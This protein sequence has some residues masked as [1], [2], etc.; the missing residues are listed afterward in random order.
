MKTILMM[1]ITA[2][3]KIAKEKNHLADWTSKEDKQLFVKLTKEAGAIIMGRTTYETIG[4]PLPGR[5]I[6]ALTST[7]EKYQ[8]I[9]GQVEYIKSETGREVLDALSAKGY[10]SAVL[11]GGAVT[12]E[13]FLKNKL[14]DE[15]YLT[16]EPVI[17]GRGL[18]LSENTDLTSR[19]KLLSLDKLNADTVLL[20]YEF[21]K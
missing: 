10:S 16:V 7:P 3:G 14:V 12:N 1:A 21:L 17:F 15:L 20:H 19:L 8:S 13:L 11:A 4:R 18:T 5:I 6:M 2:D 9:P